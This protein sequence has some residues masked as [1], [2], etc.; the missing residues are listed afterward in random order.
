MSAFL[1]LDCLELV[2]FFFPFLHL[3][4]CFF[5]LFFPFFIGCFSVP[6]LPSLFTSSLFFTLIFS[7]CLSSC[8]VYPPSIFVCMSLSLS[9]CFSS[10]ACLPSPPPHPTHTHTP[11]PFTLRL[12]F[13]SPH[14]PITSPSPHS[15]HHLPHRVIFLASC[16][17]SCPS[18]QHTL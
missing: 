11:S 10:L 12:S 15:P 5:V 1:L 8:F 7:V 18:T 13:P 2:C 17:Y 3:S 16:W 14:L 6:F 4:S 9:L